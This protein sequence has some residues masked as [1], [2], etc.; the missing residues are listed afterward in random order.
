MKI[1]IVLVA[2]DADI[3]AFFEER[4]SSVIPK[5]VLKNQD[6][7]N[8][9]V[10]DARCSDEDLIQFLLKMHA[11]HDAVGVLIEAGDE[12]RL[13]GCATFRKTFS[14][15]TAKSRNSLQNYF[16]QSLAPWLKN[17]LFL[18]KTF[19]EGKNRKCLMLPQHSFLASELNAIFLLCHA[20]NEVGNFSR[21]LDAQLKLL[22]GRSKPKTHQHDRNRK[23]YL[24]DDGAKH[25]E[26]GKERDGQSETRRPPHVVECELTASARFGM[27][28]DRFAHFNVSEAS[29]RIS[30]IFQNC[31]SGQVNQQACSHLNMFPN[32]F[33]R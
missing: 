11:N 10:L 7:C 19:S 13:R 14:S 25:F 29:G 5:T 23:E 17:L 28:M 32:G 8:A 1:A 21:S 26:L 27:T 33:I 12:S 2:R 15:A 31:H 18:L 20:E 4:R 22:R 9:V 16:G 24:V 6:R 30:G 3:L